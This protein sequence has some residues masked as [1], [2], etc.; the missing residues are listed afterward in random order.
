MTEAKHTPGPWHSEPDGMGDI[1]IASSRDPLAIAAVVNGSFMAMG[2]HAEEFEANARLITAAP[3]MLAAL[4][5]LAAKFDPAAL[6]E[7]D[8]PH[9]DLAD[10]MRA[11]FAAISKAS[12][13][14]P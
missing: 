3:D 2:G 5:A 11:A 12:G 1:T 9:S 10:E 8:L 6:V 14:Q 13:S 7:K 4:Q